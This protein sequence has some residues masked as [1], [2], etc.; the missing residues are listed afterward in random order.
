[1]RSDINV[2]V[3]VRKIVFKKI[4]QKLYNEKKHHHMPRFNFT[5]HA[6]FNTLR[7][8]KDY[9]IHSFYFRKKMIKIK[10]GGNCSWQNDVDANIHVHVDLHTESFLTLIIKKLLALF[11]HGR[12]RF[13]WRL[14]LAFTSFSLRPKHKI[15]RKNYIKLWN[16]CCKPVIVTE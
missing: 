8:R 2:F 13:W 12:C 14:D 6:H 3:L 1:M 5:Q 11:V 16:T 7:P 15:I 9:F 4:T 10:Y